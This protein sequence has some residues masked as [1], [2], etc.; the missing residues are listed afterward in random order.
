MTKEKQHTAVYE[1]KDGSITKDDH[2]MFLEDV[3]KELNRKSHLERE[4]PLLLRQAASGIC[5][6]NIVH[7]NVIANQ[8]AMMDALIN[9]DFRKGMVWIE[10]GLFGPGHLS[11]C[12]E[13]VEEG[14]TAQEYFDENEMTIL[15][16]AEYEAKVESWLKEK[17][18]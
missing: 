10:N 3:V 1:C 14:V 8:S 2:T 11:I 5:Y 18:A 9:K 4:R 6:S 16:H 15:A 12:H 7:N 13:K 17:L